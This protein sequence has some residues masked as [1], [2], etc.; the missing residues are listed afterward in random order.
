MVK[1]VNS[2]LFVKQER[3]AIV[4][5]ENEIDEN[6]F[7]TEAVPCLSVGSQIDQLKSDKTKIIQELVGIKDEN[8]KLHFEIQQKIDE[9]QKLNTQRLIDDRSAKQKIQLLERELNEWK[10]KYAIEVENQN[11]NDAM[12]SKLNREN[13]VMMAKLQQ[14]QQ[15]MNDTA[16]SHNFNGKN[17]P[18]DNKIK[19]QTEEEE[20]ESDSEFEVESLRDHKMV[21][22]K[23]LFLVRWKN[24]SSKYDTWESEKNLHCPKILEQYLKSKK[25]KK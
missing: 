22:G 21:K 19:Q 9:L 23:R 18:I 5:T 24:F 8:Q 12:I 11:K 3:E 10:Q 13:F 20:N 25:I 4:K 14:L 6:L 2:E 15:S 17:K 16:A 1:T 7:V